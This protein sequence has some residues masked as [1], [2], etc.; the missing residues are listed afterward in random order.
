VAAAAREAS[1]TA[2]TNIA[3]IVLIK[4]NINFFIPIV[5]S[6]SYKNTVYYTIGANAGLNEVYSCLAGNGKCQGE[7]LSII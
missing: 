5:L 1:G 2:M 3:V 4:T 6:R 7:V